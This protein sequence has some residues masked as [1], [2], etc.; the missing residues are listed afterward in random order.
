MT[1]P[2]TRE[3]AAEASRILDAAW[4]VL[5]RTRYE[6][7][8]VQ[9]V[10]RTSGVSVSTFYR[11]GEDRAKVVASVADFVLAALMSPRPRGAGGP[12]TAF[13]SADRAGSLRSGE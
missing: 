5:E 9:A 7:L 13:P 1:G 10:I 12:R 3:M 11:L 4:D 2:G 6:N 8:K